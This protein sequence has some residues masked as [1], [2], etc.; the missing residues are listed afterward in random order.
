MALTNL[1]ELRPTGATNSALYTRQY[2]FQ[3]PRVQC[4][5]DYI[6]LPYYNRNGDKRCQEQILNQPAEV[7]LVSRFT[8]IRVLGQ[9]KRNDQS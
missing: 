9:D 3:L 6:D 7:Y 5:K 8:H 2:K 1:H 4:L